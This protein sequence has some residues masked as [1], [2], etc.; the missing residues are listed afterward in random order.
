MRGGN[1]LY[2]ESTDLNVNLIKKYLHGNRLLLD[3][4]SGN[5]GLANWT[6]PV[7]HHTGK[8]TVKVRRSIAT[9]TEVMT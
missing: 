4:I 3:Q 6:H 5:G 9:F 1:L 2:S 7:H 8:H